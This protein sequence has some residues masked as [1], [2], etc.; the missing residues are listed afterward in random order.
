MIDVKDSIVFFGSG[1]VAAESLSL[2]AKNFVIEAVITKP[3]PP[4]HRGNFPVIDV[5]ND[6]GLKLLTATNK[7]EL[8]SLIDATDLNSKVGVVVDFGIII[9]QKVI[10]F[11]KFGIVNSHFSLLPEWRG[12]DPIT[13]AI[14]SGQSKTGVSLMII[15]PTLDTGK[16]IT[17]R[18][19]EI[20][21][22]ETTPSLTKKLIS[23]SDDLLKEFLP[24]YMSGKLKPRSQPHPDRAT[25]SR[26]LTKEDGVIDWSKS[27]DQIEREIRAF[28][29]WP[30]SRTQLANKEIIITKAHPHKENHMDNKVGEVIIDNG[31]LAV[32]CG[33]GYLCIDMLKPV[34][35]NEMTAKSFLAG[36]R[37]N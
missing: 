27:A 21:F 8:D 2:L 1:P 12:A 4:H 9:S 15:E 3:K 7:A 17:H 16:L 20:N 37:L 31:C 24:K 33:E 36:H 22:D 34:G 11:F 30:K 14:L 32:K 26:K 19:I 10:N 13:F 6:L 5:A 28:I 18:T 23:L 29:E 35:K 25:Y